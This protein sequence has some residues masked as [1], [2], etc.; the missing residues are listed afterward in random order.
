M[1]HP[2]QL[3]NLKQ[4]V[5]YWEQCLELLDSGADEQATASRMVGVVSNKQAVGWSDGVDAH[6]AYQLIFE[7]AA[8]LELPEEMTNRR[9][10]RWQCIR[11][12]L[13]VLRTATENQL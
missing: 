5:K 7:L 2:A 3:E 10:E 13:P 9:S 12:L 1:Q 8:S 6:P 4:V 11:S